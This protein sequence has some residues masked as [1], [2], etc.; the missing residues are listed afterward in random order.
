MLHLYA[1]FPPP[2]PPFTVPPRTRNALLCRSHQLVTEEVKYLTEVAEQEEEGE[3]EE[4]EEDEDEEEEEEVDEDG[5][6]DDQDVQNE[7]DMVYMKNM[8]ATDKVSPS[9]CPA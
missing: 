2:F 8:N 1:C 7:D 6:D 4:E 9:G 3:G 5:F